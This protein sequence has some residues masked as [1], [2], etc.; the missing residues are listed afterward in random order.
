LIVEDLPKKPDQLFEVGKLYRLDRIAQLTQYNIDYVRR[1]LIK[2][3]IPALRVG[4]AKQNNL[5]FR[6]EDLNDVFRV[7]IEN[8]N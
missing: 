4:N 2:S 6:G 1:E 7:V 3:R 8:T 5:R